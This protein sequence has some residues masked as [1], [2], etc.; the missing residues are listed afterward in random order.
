MRKPKKFAI[1]VIL[2]T[3]ALGVALI[4]Q[5]AS[6]RSAAS[7]P[8]DATVEPV[9]AFHSSVPAGQLPATMN[10]SL[11]TDPVAQ[12]AYNLA[13]R[14]KRV[15]YQQPCYCHCDRS[16]GHASLLDCFASKHAAACGICEREDF[17]A[18]EQAHKGK[19]G[20]QIR[21]GIVRGDWQGVDVTK[22][23]SP[24]PAPAN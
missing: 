20:A 21:E 17:Y 11:F 10:P 24:M 15:L 12:N 1:G 4:P 13:A 22:Y 19:T 6:S 9:P 14:I 3:A 16:E 23:K 18:Y 5:Q 8:Q 7:A 2:A